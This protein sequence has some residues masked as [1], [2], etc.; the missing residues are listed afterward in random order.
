MPACFVCTYAVR[1]VHW[2]M[3]SGCAA[4]LG[5]C[6]LAGHVCTSAEVQHAGMSA[7]HVVLPADAEDIQSHSVQ[8]PL[9][10]SAHSSSIAALVSV[11]SCT[12]WFCFSLHHLCRAC[13]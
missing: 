4:A 3:G 13:I 2:L 12:L 11:G 9:L 5:F 1:S 8:G 7:Q 6:C 10:T